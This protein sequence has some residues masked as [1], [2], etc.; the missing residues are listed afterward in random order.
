VIDL[1]HVPYF[2][3]GCGGRPKY[4]CLPGGLW[5][6]TLGRFIIEFAPGSLRIDAPAYTV[7]AA[8]ASGTEVRIFEDEDGLWLDCDRGKEPLSVSPVNL[9]ALE[10]HRHRDLLRVLHH[11]ILT[12]IDDGLPL[13]NFL[14]YRKPW[15]RDA[16]MVAMVLEI[17]GNVNL[18]RDWILSLR[19]PYDR[20]NGGH[21]EPDNLG[22]ALYLVSLVG[23]HG[24]GASHPIVEPVLAAAARITADGHLHGITDGREH[25]VYQTKWL[26]FGLQRL[27]LPDPYRVPQVED[28]Y[29]PL[30]WWDRQDIVVPAGKRYHA[31]AE[32]YP[33]L[34][35]AEAHFHSDPAPMHYTADGYPITWEACASQ[36][37]YEGMRPVD[38][39]FVA[40]RMSMPHTW[41][42]AEMFLYLWEESR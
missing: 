32:N 37:D 14:V 8:D 35:W 12:N 23:A 6:V 15:Y 25:P 1:S 11:E 13:P 10:G 5:A 40:R 26:K 3:F 20:N 22:Q 24:G 18:L 31:R 38:P 41:H 36:A 29:G 2:I 27:G 28:G 39:S 42:A 9:P 21:E 19:D 17:T 7:T 30:F 34:T 4:L 16:A 33:Y